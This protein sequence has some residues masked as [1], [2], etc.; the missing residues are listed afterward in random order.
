MLKLSGTRAAGLFFEPRWATLAT[1]RLFYFA[2]VD[3]VTPRGSVGLDGAEVFY[4]GAYAP[5]L[6]DPLEYAAALEARGKA[7]WSSPSLAIAE[8]HIVEHC[9]LVV[10]ADGNVVLAAAS[11]DEAFD[12][13]R[14]LTHSRDILEEALRPTASHKALYAKAAAHL[15]AKYDTMNRPSAK[16]VVVPAP[17]PRDAF[18]LAEAAVDVSSSASLARQFST[19][20]D[21]KGRRV[22]SRVTSGQT[23][24][25]SRPARTPS[26]LSAPP[27][28]AET[29]LSLG[30]AFD[31]PLSSLLTGVQLVVETRRRRGMSHGHPSTGLVL[32]DANGVLVSALHR[33]ESAQ[34]L[35][36][37]SKTIKQTSS[38][39]VETFRL[40]LLTV[41]P[42]VETICFA[43]T[44]A[45]DD[46][47]DELFGGLVGLNLQLTDGLPTGMS[48]ATEWAT[49]AW[50]L[51][52]TSQ[53]RGAQT[54]FLPALV[55]TAPASVDTGAGA[56]TVPETAMASSSQ[57][58]TS[59]KSSGWQCA[60][61][62]DF[63]KATHLAHLV[64]DLRTVGWEPSSLAPRNVSTVEFK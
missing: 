23:S 46:T 17:R 35:N 25:D 1:G 34:E 58:A 57:R 51:W 5:E 47:S 15:A 37:V 56:G 62:L 41:P 14:D 50:E 18:L 12:W 40:D 64:Y 39:R 6:G 43:L 13:M 19:R 4:L 29:P 36:Y 8:A 32:L 26:G 10:S 30:D 3:D 22:G 45:V 9:F 27:D 11:E 49:G 21:G 20:A 31:L 7:L 52:L 63:S 38:R 44:R 28:A 53:G 33:D 42:Q 16:P 61:R 59:V 60:L 24:P 48:A 2:N 54:I 55:R